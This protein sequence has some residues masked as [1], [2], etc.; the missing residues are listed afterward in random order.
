MVNDSI[1]QHIDVQ[2]NVKRSSTH[3]RHLTEHDILRNAMTIIL[4][5]NS[6]SLH[7]DFNGLL[8]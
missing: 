8:E 2:R 3:R 1:L 6:G 5:T 4:L 7:Q